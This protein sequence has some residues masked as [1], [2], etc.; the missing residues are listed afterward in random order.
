MDTKSIKKRKIYLNL[1]FKM[2]SDFTFLFKSYKSFVLEIISL[3][4]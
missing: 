4:V 2:F 3:S 1:F